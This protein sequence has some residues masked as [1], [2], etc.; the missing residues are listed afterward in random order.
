MF[1][2]TPVIEEGTQSGFMRA[3]QQ[4]RGSI[5]ETNA[6]LAEQINSDYSEIQSKWIPNEGQTIDMTKG[7]RRKIRWV[8]GHNANAKVAMYAKFQISDS[9]IHLAWIVA[10]PTAERINC[11]EGTAPF[12]SMLA[13]AA[14][15]GQ[16]AHKPI[17][18]LADNEPL[19]VKYEESGFELNRKSEGGKPE[20]EL[21]VANLDRPLTTHKAQREGEH[22]V[23]SGEGSLAEYVAIA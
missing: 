17:L 23:F 20:M 6:V 19:I 5:L 16:I 3:A 10:N 22:W 12:R 21:S 7:F 8:F 4:W 2:V 1:Y 14:R 13:F 9:D 15:M 18:L 11:G